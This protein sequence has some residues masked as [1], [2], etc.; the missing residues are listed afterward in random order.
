MNEGLQRAPGLTLI[1]APAGFGKTTLVSEWVSACGRPVAWLS[2][3]E[4]D[5]DLPRFLTYLVTAVQTIAAP[6]GQRLL[7][8][9]QSPQPHAADSLLITLVNDLAAIPEKFVLVLDDYHRIESKPVDDALAFLV[10]HQPPQMHL[11]IVSRQDPPLPL[12]RLRARGQLI[13]LRAADLR[14]T[15][16]EAAEFLNVGMGLNLSAEDVT[17]LETRTEGWIAGLQLATLA[18]QG[19]DDMTGFIRAFTGSH[20]FVLDYLVDEV[21]HRQ[22]EHVRVF[23]LQTAILDRFC[24]ALCNAV[25]G[26]DDSKDMLAS[27]ERRNLFLIQLDDERHWY[28][29]HHL[30]A[31][32]LQSHLT[33][34]VPGNISQL[35][36][37]A[38]VWYEQNGLRPDA[39]RHA[40]AAKDFEGAADLIELAR[41]AAEQASISETAWFG[42]VKAL[43]EAA[44][45]VRPVLSVGYALAL[46][47]RGDLET[48]EARLNDADRWI[49]AA[50]LEKEQLGR[51][52]MDMV[53]ADRAQ[54]ESLPATAAIGR[55]YIAQSR[56]NMQDTARYA[57]RALEFSTDK[58]VYRRRQATLMLAMISWT[59]G[60]LIAA[61][62]AFAEDT[63]KLRATGMYLAA[64]DTTVVLGE[65]RLSL[66]RLQDAIEAVEQLLRYLADQGEPISPDAAELHRELGELYLERD[67]RQAAAQQFLKSK[68]IGEKV[69][70]PIWRY[71]WIIAQARL[72]A[73]QGNPDAALALLD[74]AGRLYVRTPL[75]DSHPIAAMKVRVWLRHGGLAQALAWVREQGLSVDDDLSFLREYDYLTLARTLI[76][77]YRQERRQTS[78]HAAARLL[79]R[80][81]RSA[82]IG[83]RMGS[84]IE[85]LTVQAL[86]HQAQG[87]IP[88]ALV[89]LNRALTLAEP[90]GFVRVFADEGRPLGE[91]LAQ[92][93]AEQ[94]TWR[95]KAYIRQLQSAMDLRRVV[96]TSTGVPAERQESLPRS[97][98][99]NSAH[100]LIEPLSAHELDVLRLLGTEMSGPEIARERVVSLNTIRTQTQHI[101]AKLGVNNRRAAVRRAEELGLL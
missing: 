99:A 28:R 3:D 15:P 65:I 53:V 25:T 66:G 49:E 39:I 54:W 44:L 71:R 22:P 20:R 30:F 19:R 9:L 18:M 88:S 8:H 90:E 83:C 82:E 87:N 95:A 55:A 27:L 92:L 72:D 94:P 79:D 68:E 31:V 96:S 81:L 32:V 33:E 74:E 78:I 37:R 5:N 43:P 52:P 70:L 50:G 86:V 2:L 64:V 36:Q 76:A 89:S 51:H 14:F 97:K 13:E 29:Y 11:V 77:Q 10:E 35:H 48:A 73:I 63:V 47:S 80:L 75:P 67:Q 24:S 60:D 38:S 16:A 101:Y 21:L 26:R 59:N 85:I 93:E 7:A 69:E 40:L 17:A 34:A 45:R 1:S 12:P 56:G 42:W 46:L 62:R 23:L 58:D 91:L 6:V 57:H 84:V 4:E 98:P 61:D 100:A 41:P